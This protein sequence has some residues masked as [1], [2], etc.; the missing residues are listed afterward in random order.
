MGFGNY[1]LGI[2]LILFAVLIALPVIVNLP[3]SWFGAVLV[4]A[5]LGTGAYLVWRGA[6]QSR[7]KH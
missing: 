4:I 3:E 7:K 2:V 1:I 6:A 5:M